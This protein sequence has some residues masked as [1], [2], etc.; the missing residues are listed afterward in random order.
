MTQYPLVVVD[1][2]LTEHG[3]QPNANIGVE[4]KASFS[5]RNTCSQ[6][7]PHMNHAPLVVSWIKE[8]LR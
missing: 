7:L 2:L 1:I 3:Y 6:S 8:K 5:R 4:V